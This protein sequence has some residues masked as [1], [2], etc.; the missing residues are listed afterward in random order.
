MGGND[1]AVAAVWSGGYKWVV[2]HTPA[3]LENADIRLLH[4]GG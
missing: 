2:S 3:R 4:Q 1:L